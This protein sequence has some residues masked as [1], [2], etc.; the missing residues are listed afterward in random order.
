M[1]EAT[2]EALNDY[3]RDLYAPEDEALVYARVEAAERG[4]PPIHIGPDEGRMLQVLLAAVGAKR[5][6]EIGTL[7]GYS[8]TWIA[9]ALPADGRLYTLDS[10][11]DHS[12][13]ARTTFDRA[14]L[15]GRVVTRV[16]KAPAALDD[17]AAEGPF[18]A[19]FIDA[20]KD[21]Y[22]AYLRWA[23][24]NVRIG[25]IIM[26][27]NAFM[28]GRIVGPELQTDAS[29]QAMDAFNHALADDPRVLG[30]IIPIGDGIAAAV[31]LR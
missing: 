22:P 9:R 4:M 8:G 13:M 17:L 21:G 18:D 15:D 3:V 25:G 7:A 30:T 11:P 2:H 12:A 16:G 27:H 1:D 28:R 10:D 6:A 29:V 5:V 23:V 20:N 26:A 19:V 14:G 24:A 31:R